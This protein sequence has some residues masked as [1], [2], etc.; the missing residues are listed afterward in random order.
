MPLVTEGFAASLTEAAT[1]F[2]I[3]EPAVGTILIGKGL[4]R[5]LADQAVDAPYSDEYC[6]AAVVSGKLAAENPA[7][8]AKVTRA[9][10]KGARWVN[11]NPTAAAK[12]SVEKGYLASSVEVNT[13]ALSKLKYIPGVSKCRRSIDQA[14]DEM[15]NIKMKTGSDDQVKVWLNGKEV[16]KFAEPRAADKDQDSTEVTLQK[17]INVLVAKVVNEKIDWSF[18]VR[19]TDKDDKP[20]TTLKAKT[21]Q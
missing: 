5:T 21:S 17:G 15:K 2:A 1:R 10:L 11:D 13:Q 16:F 8:A 19:F 4:V 9:L 12:L 6:C 20:I 18:C 3:T 14:A 7:A